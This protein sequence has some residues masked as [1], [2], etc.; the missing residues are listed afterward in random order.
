MSKPM[1]GW[2]EFASVMSQQPVKLLQLL[3]PLFVMILNYALTKLMHIQRIN[4]LVKWIF[5]CA[6]LTAIH[7]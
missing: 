2:P 4:S 1:S 3:V 7:D 5:N 6:P